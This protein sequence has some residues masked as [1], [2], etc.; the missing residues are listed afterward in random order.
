MGLDIFSAHIDRTHWIGAP[1]KQSVK[2]DTL[3][4][5]L[6][7]TT[8]GEKFI[9]K[10]ILNRTKVFI[11]ESLTAHPVVKLREAKEKFSFKNGWSNVQ[12]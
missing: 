1:S 3:L 2:L 6:Y 12:R 5:S 4:L 8:T 7:G 10:Q 11:T 9:N